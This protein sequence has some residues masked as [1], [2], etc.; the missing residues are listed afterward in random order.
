M[1]TCFSPF[2]Y[3]KLPTHQYEFA[4]YEGG[5]VESSLSLS[6]SSVTHPAPTSHHESNASYH[7]RYLVPIPQAIETITT[8][9]DPG[10][11]PGR[12]ANTKRTAK[13]ANLIQ[14]SRESVPTTLHQKAELILPAM[15]M[16]NMRSLNLDKFNEL[17]VVAEDYD[18][19]MITESW[20][21]AD[22]ET[23]YSL[24]NFVL[25]SCH[26]GGK[27]LGG[28]VAVYARNN[29]AVQKL[30]DH[31]SKHM[32]AY[33]FALKHQDQPPIIYGVLYHPPGLKKQQKDDT[34]NY[35]IKTIATLQTK[36]TSA[37]FLLC[38]DFNDLDTTEI[39]NLLPL[40]QLVDFPTRENRMLDLIFTNVQEYID[41]GCT[42]K[43]PIL[44]N[45]HCAVS[46]PPTKRIIKPKYTTIQ[47][48]MVTPEAKIAITQELSTYS[49]DYIYQA[50]SVDEKV[51]LLQTSMQELY[52][53]HCPTRSVRVPTDKP[54]ITS[55]L[56]RKLIRA[57]Q[58]AHKRKNPS[59]KFLSKQLSRQLKNALKKQ[60]DNNINNTVQGTRNWWRNIKAITGERTTT[61]QADVINIADEWLTNTEFAE[62]LN[63][64]YVEQQ[65]SSVINTPHIPII[66]DHGI[67]VDE[68][69][70]AKLLDNI[71]TR[72]A[73]HSMDFPSWISKNNSYLLSAPVTDIINSILASGTFPAVWKQAEVTPINKVKS[74][75][76][77]KDMR[78]ISL[79]FHLSKIAEKVVANH[80]Q[81]GLPSFIDQ[82]AYTKAI[83]TTDALVKFSTDLIGSLD[84]DNN[85]AAQALLLDFSKAFDR[86][87]PEYA[88][89]KLLNLGV[90]PPL[91]SV[92]HSFLTK[93]VQRVKYAGEMSS[94]KSCTVGVPQGTILGPLLWNCFVSDLSPGGV[95]TMK[96]ADDTTLYHT[97][98][99]AG[100]NIT[101]NTSSTVTLNIPDNPLQ[102]AADYAADWCDKNSMCLN[103]SKSH[104]I[105]F[106]IKK[107]ITNHT[108]ISI[109][110]TDIE[111]TQTAKL[112]GI[113]YDQH[114]KFGEHVNSIL[115]KSRSAFHA[116][117]QLKK[118]GLDAN[119][120]ARFYQC[121]ILPILTYAAPSWYPMITQANKDRLEKYQR[122][123][124]RIISP[125]KDCYEDRLRQFGISEINNLLDIVC[126]RYVE[127]LKT[128]HGHPLH[129]YTF[130]R[131]SSLRKSR[132]IL[133]KHR[134][135]FFA[136]SLFYRYI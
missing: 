4:F 104:V 12:A 24:D 17:K 83:G 9:R 6:R 19:I 103:T 90:K 18:L 8:L 97:I 3:C 113:T 121:R 74:P 65:D 43:P 10:R 48:H 105:T 98:G 114:M 112:L 1:S 100:A 79:L 75:K 124:L 110:N 82:F 119:S 99:K 11:Y 130:Q 55:P 5:H 21:N 134:T 64:Y 127:K 63:A 20:L 36:Y 62:K 57:K 34:I 30:C 133:T 50:T 91:V 120:L 31:T 26:R 132:R 118:A 59:W 40:E 7:R 129:S 67:S 39:T 116:L 15:Y 37:K 58:R 69:S 76:E 14:I 70:V 78:P 25:H 32:S 47:K 56:I 49:W 101:D 72:K 16:H 73:T 54:V 61:N 94:Y 53:K 60:S 22:K 44:N 125:Y 109:N 111:E 41:V 27:R 77:Y 95:N 85:V 45:D 81:T 117:S 68:H 136:K 38:G 33:W 2:Y 13:P 71:N 51:E 102:H 92:V 108:S 66:A 93:R 107:S 126:L 28:G 115:A 84:D 29:L 23:L 52:D 35:I 89:Q 128:D 96:Y 46:L 135:G 131:V 80:I 123:C 122:L 42:Q 106:S 86:M 88:V 87:R